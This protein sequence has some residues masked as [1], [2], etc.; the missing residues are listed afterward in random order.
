MR[1]LILTLAFLTLAA[2]LFAQ[3]TATVEMQLV[4]SP[5]FTTRIQYLLAQQAVIVLAEPKATVCHPYRVQFGQQVIANPA[6]VAGTSSVTIASGTNLTSVAVTGTG[7]TADSAATD[8]AIASQI[9]TYWNALSR[10]E[11]GT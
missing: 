7:L 11:T 10:C 9:A 1:R 4:N 3:N 6:T 5:V 2:P 8:A